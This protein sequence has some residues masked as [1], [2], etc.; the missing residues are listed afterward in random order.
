MPNINRPGTSR[1][2]SRYTWQEW[3]RLSQFAVYWDASAGGEI[4][5]SF[6]WLASLARMIQHPTCQH[7]SDC[8][9]DINVILVDL[10]LIQSWGWKQVY[11]CEQIHPLSDLLS[12]SFGGSSHFGKH[13]ACPGKPSTPFHLTNCQAD[14][15][16]EEN[17]MK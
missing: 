7:Q 2:A 14:S 9:V 10:L 3:R 17:D 4:H 5:G 16:S 6:S 1:I 8:M 11:T 12:F 15:R 13:M